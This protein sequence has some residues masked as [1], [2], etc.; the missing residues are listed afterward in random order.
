MGR[1]SDKQQE[2]LWT[3]YGIDAA[4]VE[5]ADD[6][7]R[8]EEMAEVDEGEAEAYLIQNISSKKLCSVPRADL[9]E[10][11]VPQA[12]K[13]LHDPVLAFRP[14]HDDGLDTLYLDKHGEQG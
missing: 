14:V 11:M 3:R 4:V 8:E 9:A 10:D 1:S 2:K 5:G 13:E 7:R 12:L 6:L